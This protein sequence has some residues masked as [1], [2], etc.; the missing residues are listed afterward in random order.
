LRSIVGALTINVVLI[1]FFV[2][3]IGKLDMKRWGIYGFN[4]VKIDAASFAFAA[5]ATCLM[6]SS[7]ASII[8]QT[9]F[10]GF[11]GRWLISCKWADFIIYGALPASNM[12]ALIAGAIV[13]EAMIAKALS[14]IA[15]IAS[16]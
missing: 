8:W 11:F 15:D 3:I 9:Q 1:M 7:I 5:I 12:V 13:A 6:F 4:I 2:R 16:G 14:T 10:S